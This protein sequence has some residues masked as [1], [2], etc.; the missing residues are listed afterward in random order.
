MVGVLELRLLLALGVPLS[1]LLSPRSISCNIVIDNMFMF[2]L[3][4]IIIIYDMMT[5]YLHVLIIH[6]SITHS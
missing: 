2:V 1:P 4:I 5:T 6:H 3:N